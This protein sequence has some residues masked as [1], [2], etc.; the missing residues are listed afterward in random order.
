MPNG[1]KRPLPIKVRTRA[2][3]NIETVE[4]YERLAYMSSDTNV[5]KSGLAK[6]VHNI[7][8]HGIPVASSRATQ[9]RARK[10][11]CRQM[12]P[13]GPLVTEIET[14]ATTNGQPINIPI[15]NPFAALFLAA[16]KSEDFARV[17]RR[18]LDVNP[19]SH[20]HPWRIMLYQDGVDP[21]DGLAKNHS[22]KSNVFYWSFLELGMD[23]LCHEECWF[24]ITLARY[25]TS[26]MLDGGITQLTSI[27]MDSLF[28]PT[29]DGNNM[30]TKGCTLTIHGEEFVIFADLGAIVSDEPAIKEMLACT[31]HAGTKPCVLCTNGVLHKQPRSDVGLWESNDWL[32]SIAEPDLAR[33]KPH[34]NESI[35]RAVEKIAVLHRTLNKT[36]FKIKRAIYGFGFSPFNIITRC[37]VNVVSCLMYD[38]VHTFVCDGNAD[39]EFGMCMKTLHTAKSATTYTEVRDYLNSWRFPKV[40]GIGIDRLFSDTASHNNLKKGAFGSTAS[41][42]LTIAPVL[43]VYFVRVCSQRHASNPDLLKYVLS[44][45]AVLEIVLLCNAIKFGST[46]S[47]ELHAAIT[48]HFQLFVDAYGRGKAKPKHHYGLHLGRML[49]WFGVLVGTLTHERK[50]RVIKRNTRNRDNLRNWNLGSVHQLFEL[51]RQF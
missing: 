9:Y 3:Q 1:K 34:T 27:L 47:G 2:E 44:M 14:V 49:A 16:S 29:A 41:E 15:Q 45:I 18:A 19:C 30:K 48:A 10:K 40:Y 50:H 25:N 11:L 13:Y 32:T 4:R 20:D 36:Q 23:A 22:R 33:F 26:M 24:T 31:G 5:S 51:G 12:T 46:T 8:D 21:S 35:R 37:F 38:W 17:M 39:S 28:S 7:R 6:L 42:F 43:L